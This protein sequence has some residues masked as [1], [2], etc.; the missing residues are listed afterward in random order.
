[1]KKPKPAYWWEIIALALLGLL[2]AIMVEPYLE[3]NYWHHGNY[4]SFYA[5][6]FIFYAYPACM[7][8]FVR[9]QISQKYGDWRILILQLA[10]LY[11]LF[12]LVFRQ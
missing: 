3:R 9:R 8:S 4:H 7:L 6:W 10:S 11:A 1:M 12:F 2:G 5:A